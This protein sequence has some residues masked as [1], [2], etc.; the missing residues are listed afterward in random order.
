MR[1]NRGLFRSLTRG[2][3]TDNADPGPLVG[4]HEAQL[5]NEDHNL[6]DS[7]DNEQ[8]SNHNKWVAPLRCLLDYKHA[9]LLLLTGLAL[10][11]LG[12]LVLWDGINLLQAGNPI[13]AQRERLG[14]AAF[15][16]ACYPVYRALSELIVG[17]CEPMNARRI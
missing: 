3:H 7:T 1:Q 8:S 13:G 11:Y 10:A 14:I 4:P 16:A 6:G 9:L 5:D 15:V 17:T 2:I 12:S